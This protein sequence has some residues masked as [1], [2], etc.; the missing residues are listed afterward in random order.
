MAYLSLIA[1]ALATPM[2]DAELLTPPPPDQLEALAVELG[3]TID[4]GY[5]RIL[6]D[7][8]VIDWLRKHGHEIHVHR[9]DHRRGPPP[10]GY[11]HPD[12]LASV[13]HELANASTRA[14]TSVIGHSLLG[15]PIEGLW[16]GQAPD[17]G[18]PVIR[19]LGGHHGDEA[20]SWEVVIATATELV[21]SDSQVTDITNL[22]DTTTVWVVPI[23]NPDGATEGSRYN[24]AAVDLNRNYDLEWSADARSAGPHPFSEPET[25]AVRTLADYGGFPW[26]SLS[27]HSGATN[28]GYP[29]N[30]S[31]EA[32]IDE[33][34]MVEI[35]DTYGENC[36]NEDFWVT[37]GAD[38]YITQGDTNDWSY[39]RYGGFDM[40][41]EVTQSKTPAAEE[42]G[43]FVNDHL[44]AMLGFVL[45]LPGAAGEV[46][47]AQSGRP[48]P[49]RITLADDVGQPVAAPVYADPHT[50]HFVVAN[51]SMATTMTVEA[52]GYPAI[53]VNFPTEKIEIDSS[54]IQPVSG[55]PFIVAPGG[56][57][58]FDVG[59]STAW[60]SRPGHAT[61]TAPILLGSLAIPNDIAAGPWTVSTGG[62][63]WPNGLFVMDDLAPALHSYE[64]LDQTMTVTGSSFTR[65]TRAYGVWGAERILVPFDV[66]DITE[67]TVEFNISQAEKND[68]DLV[69]VTA[70]RQVA[71]AGVS[72]TDQ[73]VRLDDLDEYDEVRRGCGCNSSG[74]PLSIAIGAA[75]LALSR[76]RRR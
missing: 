30:W 4:H 25:A 53:S 14:G 51:T 23:V 32:P 31:T 62:Q 34:R 63:T 60:L 41:L 39:G 29:W 10:L 75:F 73:L 47:D 58:T 71:V 74:A 13:L 35:A 16:I 57:S 67:F 59:T 27:V 70:G 17:S 61:L 3:F 20:S 26:L 72:P 65:G 54:G 49:A 36:H 7:E 5:G 15:A 76:R 37:N 56:G 66:V 40:T 1:A 55:R 18:A 12:Q 8:Y 33:I 19:L 11:V 24:N 9:A 69:L 28:I 52:P 42:I 38:W 45:T 68:F 21:H 50:G 2:A 46:V 64:R 48:V 6:A 44:D 22:L 43:E